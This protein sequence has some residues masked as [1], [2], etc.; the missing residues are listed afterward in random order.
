M[1]MD[2]QMMAMMQGTQSGAQQAQ[3]I[4][5]NAAQPQGAPNQKVAILCGSL[6]LVVDRLNE[7]GSLL[8]SQGKTELANDL[9]KASFTTNTVVEKLEKEASGDGSSE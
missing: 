3:S 8:N 4:M 2:P 9:Y 5:P 6:K 1:A 7:L